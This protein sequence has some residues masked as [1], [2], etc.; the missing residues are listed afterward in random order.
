[1]LRYLYAGAKQCSIAFMRQPYDEAREAMA[2][3][4]ALGAWQEEIKLEVYYRL[5][6]TKSEFSGVAPQLTQWTK[7]EGQEWRQCGGVGDGDEG[8]GDESGEDE[9]TG[10]GTGAGASTVQC[11]ITPGVQ[12]MLQVRL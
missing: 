6:I 12:F 11:A 8:D 10:A 2:K 1:M 3:K 9:S 5:V 7:R 4:G